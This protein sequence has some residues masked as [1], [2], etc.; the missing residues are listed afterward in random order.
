[1]HR[2]IQ[3]TYNR[4]MALIWISPYNKIMYLK[5]FIFSDANVLP[6]LSPLCIGPHVI[7]PSTPKKS[8][9]II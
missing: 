5:V 4:H 2:G 3:C 9:E 7:I 8:F 1:M 6:V